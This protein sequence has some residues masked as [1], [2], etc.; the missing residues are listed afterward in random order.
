M[1]T[2]LS[3]IASAIILGCILSEHPNTDEDT[4]D[5]RQEARTCSTDFMCEL[6]VD[7]R[8]E[9]LPSTDATEQDG[10]IGGAAA[11][12]T[13]GNSGTAER[14][15]AAGTSGST[16][17]EGSADNPG[18]SGNAGSSGTAGSIDD[19]GTGGSADTIG[20]G[21]EPGDDAMPVPALDIRLTFEGGY[22]FDVHLTHPLADAWFDRNYDCHFVSPAPDWG[23]LGFEGDDG[24]LLVDNTGDED[25]LGEERLILRQ[26][27]SAADFVDGRYRIG[28]HFY[29]ATVSA[30]EDSEPGP[31]IRGQA[32]VTI[33]LNDNTSYEFVHT[34]EPWQMWHVADFTWSQD[35][36]VLVETP[37]RAEPNICE[38]VEST[39]NGCSF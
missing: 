38:P 1:R 29:R 17:T 6:N 9:C 23:Q 7:G 37:P 16:A 8:Y 13:A 19:P 3:I 30:F 32:R 31:S 12:G 20:D 36:G 10:G 11:I 15:G 35:G 22:D 34:L 4:Q 26:P 24:Q 18:S 28:I 2:L 14:S 25:A 27:Q 5:C 39:A 33:R 21:D